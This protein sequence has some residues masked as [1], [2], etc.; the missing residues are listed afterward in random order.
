MS[1]E[2]LK[3]PNSFFQ[4][5]TV[6]EKDIDSLNHVNNVVYLQWVNDIAAAHWSNLSNDEIN[7]AYYWVCLRH[8]IDYLGEAFV[9]DKLCIH[10]WITSS[11]GV[12]S[13]RH[14]VI[15]KGDKI[16]AK[17]VSTWCLINAETK[18]PRRINKKTMGFMT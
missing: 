8:E 15:C 17:V 3:M 6:Q 4:Y 9:A 5:Y 14:V 10:T 1:A 18:K 13:I 11:I 16:I 7:K 2:F 12:K